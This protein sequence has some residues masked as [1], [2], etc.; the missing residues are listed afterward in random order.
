MNRRIKNSKLTIFG[1]FALFD[2]WLIRKIDGIER[3]SLATRNSPNAP[4]TIGLNGENSKA[5]ETFFNFFSQKFCRYKNYLYICTTKNDG[6]I[7]Q[8]VEQR[9]ENPCVP[10]SIPGGTTERKLK[11]FLFFCAVDR[12]L[13]CLETWGTYC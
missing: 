13:V 3:T 4:A 7:A 11:G 2:G 10:G 1:C 9:T 6:A 12:P 5:K 8:L